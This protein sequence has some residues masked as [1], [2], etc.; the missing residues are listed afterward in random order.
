MRKPAIV[1]VIAMSLAFVSPCTLGSH[2]AE[3]PDFE[4]FVGDTDKAQQYLK[5]AEYYNKKAEGYER[6]ALY[7]NQQAEGYIKQADYYT[8]KK[9]TRRANTYTSR[10]N[11]AF[12]KAKLRMKWAKDARE[13]A[14]LRLKW[15]RQAAK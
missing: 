11:G 8:R 9:D 14:Q 3:T 7:Y 2:G 13:K 12:S 1:S 10:A 5:E 6:E 4:S 15:A